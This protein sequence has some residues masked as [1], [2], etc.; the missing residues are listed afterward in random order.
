MGF[1]GKIKQN[2][3]RGGIKVNLQA[4]ASASMQEAN[5]PVTVSITNAG[6]QQ[7]INSVKVEIIATSRNQSFG[8]PDPNSNNQV[9]NQTV[10]RADNTEQFVIMPGETKTVQISLVMNAGAAA[11][12]QLPEGSSMAQV[13]GALQK[14][15]TVSEAMSGDNYSYTIRASADVEGVTLDPRKEKPIQILK[16]GQIGGAF[17]VG[18]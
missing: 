12:S 14:L 5:L 11:Q 9:V 8:T 4:P 16:P 2:L 6:E 15:Q 13:A 17:N 7:T 1:F 10:A 3:N 18:V